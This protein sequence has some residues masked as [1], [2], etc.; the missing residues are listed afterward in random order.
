MLVAVG[1]AVLYTLAKIDNNQT[2]IAA[3]YPVAAVDYLQASGLDEGAG[4]TATTGAATSSGAACP[5]L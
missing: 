5:C 4:Y 2:A 3:R 1:T